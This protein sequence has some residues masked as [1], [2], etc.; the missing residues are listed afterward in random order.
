MGWA[1]RPLLLASTSPSP[2]PRSP[3][4]QYILLETEVQIPLSHAGWRCDDITRVRTYCDTLQALIRRFLDT[5]PRIE[6][7]TESTRAFARRHGFVRTIVGRLR[8][9][10]SITICSTCLAGLSRSSFPSSLSRRMPW[11]PFLKFWRPWNH[12]RTSPPETRDC[13]PRRS[14]KPSTRSSRWVIRPTLSESLSASSMLPQL[15]VM[16]IVPLV[17]L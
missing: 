16:L 1:P 2:M 3:F 13:V 7:F 5:F 17:C 12:S 6:R 4:I 9:I 8:H 10:V 14:V 11:H 15:Y